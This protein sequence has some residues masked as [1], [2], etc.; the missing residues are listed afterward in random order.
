LFEKTGIIKNRAEFVMT[1]RGPVPIELQPKDFDY[2]YYINK[3][4][5]PVANSILTLIGEDFDQLRNDQ[6]SL[7]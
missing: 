4:L 1:L 6:L 3:Q 2:E 7:F 5:S